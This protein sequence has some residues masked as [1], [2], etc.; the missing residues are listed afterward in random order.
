[1]KQLSHLVSFGKPGFNKAD[2]TSAPPSFREAVRSNPSPKP[3]TSTSQSEEK[4]E[5]KEETIIQVLEE[6]APDDSAFSFE[7]KR[8]LA[9]RIKN[10]G[11]AAA[12]AVVEAMKASN[13]MWN[14]VSFGSSTSESK[15]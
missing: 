14:E 11:E 1:M 2:P 9:L 4:E 12:N 6:D 15:V 7:E 8:L 5:K 13:A 10:G 3:S